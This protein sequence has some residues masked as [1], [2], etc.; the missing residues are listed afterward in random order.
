MDIHALYASLL[1]G[2]CPCHGYN[3]SPGRTGR[4]YH[5]VCRHFTSSRIFTMMLF[6]HQLGCYCKILSAD[7]QSSSLSQGYVQGVP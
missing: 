6:G 4:F 1:V 5:L 7:H 3:K 2:L